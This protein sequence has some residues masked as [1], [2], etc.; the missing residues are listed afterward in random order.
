MTARRLG[1]GGALVLWLG[2]AAAVPP[3]FAQAP[4]PK[5][6]GAASKAPSEAEALKAQ[7]DEAMVSLRYADALDFYTR[8]YDLEKNPAL[9]YNRARALEALTRFPDALDQ[10]EAFARE[11]PDELKAKVPLLGELLVELRGKVSELSVAA[12]VAGARVLVRDQAVGTTPLSSPL[13]LNAGT[14]SIEV[15]A[16]GYHPWKKQVALPGGGKLDIAAK[17]VTRATTG[18]LR[19]TSPVAGALVLVDDERIGA[20]P[21]EVQVAAGPH[22]VLVQKQGYEPVRTTAVVSVG[23]RREMRVALDEI[24]PITARWWFWAGVGVVVAGGT[25]LTV[26]LLTERSA[27]SGDIEPGRVSGPLVEF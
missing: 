21:A 12:N 11:A 16:D 20:V 24:P 17:L 1:L 13:R 15:T 2:I 22:R 19:V 27:D 5:G 25:A 8:G 7:G 26:A 23:G 10:L 6:K 4:K 9:L 3:A 18:V 14:A